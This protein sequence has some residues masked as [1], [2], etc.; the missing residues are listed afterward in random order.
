MERNLKE[1]SGLASLIL[2]GMWAVWD[3]HILSWRSQ[4]FSL[5][6]YNLLMR[7]EGNLLYLQ[8]TDLNISLT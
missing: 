2:H 4:P 1:L 5:K 3:M 8:S 6:N 7:L